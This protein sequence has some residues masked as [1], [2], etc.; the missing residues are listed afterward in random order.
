[1]DELLIEVLRTFLGREPNDY[2]FTKCT[3]AQW[4]GEP[5][6]F[7]ISYDGTLLGEFDSEIQNKEGKYLLVHTFKPVEKV[8]N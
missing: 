3:M 8:N 1:M 7:Q 6:R 5:D 2:D 4:V